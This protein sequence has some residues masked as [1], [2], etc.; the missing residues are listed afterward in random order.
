MNNLDNQKIK[1][2]TKILFELFSK[3]EIARHIVTSIV[4]SLL[5]IAG[6]NYQENKSQIRQFEVALDRKIIYLNRLRFEESQVTKSSEN[7][8]PRYK[9]IAY[10]LFQL[11]DIKGN[12][13]SEMII[14]CEND[15]KCFLQSISIKEEEIKNL[16]NQYNIPQQ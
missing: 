13:I 4:I 14:N 15:E 3:S 5:T 10:V 7:T 6:I 9:Q 16:F 12:K 2:L 11:L 1:N 8:T